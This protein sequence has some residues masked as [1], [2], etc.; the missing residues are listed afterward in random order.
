MMAEEGT[1]QAPTG[2]NRQQMEV[3]GELEMWTKHC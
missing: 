1:G 3:T 2:G